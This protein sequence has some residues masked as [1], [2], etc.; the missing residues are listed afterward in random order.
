[1]KIN[2]NIAIS[3]SGFLLNPATGESFSLNSMG[4]KVLKLMN[5]GKDYL[6]IEKLITNEFDVSNSTFDKDYNDFIG[7]LQ[8]NHLV[9]T[10]ST[11][12]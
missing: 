10:E 12:A 7:L 4:I 11:K 1:M 6:E 9:E 8:Q 5:E 3:D 2:K